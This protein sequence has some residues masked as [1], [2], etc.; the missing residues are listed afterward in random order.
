MEQAKKSEALFGD[1]DTHEGTFLHAMKCF[2]E[3]M[4]DEPHALSNNGALTGAKGIHHLA[5]GVLEKRV[6]CLGD[7]SEPPPEA[8]IHQHLKHPNLAPFDDNKLCDQADR[9]NVLGPL[10]RALQKDHTLDKYDDYMEAHLQQLSVDEHLL[11]TDER[12]KPPAASADDLYYAFYKK[13]RNH[14]SKRNLP[15]EFDSL[16]DEKHDHA[17]SIPPPPLPPEDRDVFRRP[18]LSNRD[19]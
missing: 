3:W 16:H 9:P 14:G 1:I 17:L 5:E 7:C 11:L 8:R 4:W 10:F 13:L 19:I 15:P 12:G 18:C 2:A 6:N